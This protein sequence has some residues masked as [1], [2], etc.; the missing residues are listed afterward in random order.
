MEK[1]FAF[2][3]IEEETDRALRYARLALNAMGEP[4]KFQDRVEISGYLAEARAAIDRATSLLS[5]SPANARSRSRFE[6]KV[7]NIEGALRG[8]ELRAEIPQ[9]A[10]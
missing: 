7:L 1:P 5:Q 2:T 9:E 4:I 3:H 10:A 8:I 6:S